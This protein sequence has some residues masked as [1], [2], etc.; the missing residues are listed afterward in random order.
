MAKARRSATTLDKARARPKTF[1]E[2]RL[3]LLHERGISLSDIA[4]SLN[5]GLSAASRV[6]KGTRRSQ[7]I[8]REIARRLFLT[9]EE[10]FPEWH[11]RRAETAR[12]NTAKAR[13]QQS[14]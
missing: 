7:T 10:A 5:I 14:N 2:A 6:N 3:M 11:G 1:G 13:T 8:E 9:E 4:R 12:K